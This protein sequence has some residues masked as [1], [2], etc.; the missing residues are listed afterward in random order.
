[1]NRGVQ[2]KQMRQ[3]ITKYFE[4]IKNLKDFGFG[5]Y[6]MEKISRV[7]YGFRNFRN[8]RLRVLMQCA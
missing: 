2:K 3:I 8:Y 5:P 4:I 1:M 6:K 7:A